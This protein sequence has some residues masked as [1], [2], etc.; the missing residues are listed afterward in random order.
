MAQ[1]CLGV[2]LAPILG[3]GSAVLGQQST[4]GKAKKA[5][6]L[7]MSGGMTHL[8]T[9]D[10]KPGTEVGGP[11]EAISTKASG[12]RISEHFPKLAQRLNKLTV[13]RGMTSNQGAHGPGRYLAH[14]SYAPRASIQHAGMGAW[15]ANV[16]G[17]LNKNIP[18]NIVINGGSDH[19]GAGY[20]DLKYAPLPIGSP[21]AGLKNSKL[22]G[23]VTEKDF[24]RRLNMVAKFGQQFLRRYPHKKVKGY[25]EMYAE[26]IRLMRSEDVKAF[27]V[28]EEDG[29]LRNEYGRDNFGQGCL[30]ARRLLERDVRFVEVQLGG[31][32][33]HNETFE[34]MPEKGRVVDNAVSALLD[35]LERT[36]LIKETVVILTSEFGRSPRINERAGRDHHPAAFSSL[37]AGAGIK[38]GYVHGASDERGHYVEDGE[39]PIES[40]NATIATAL[41][42]P[43]D[44]VEYSGSGRP[45]KVAN[46]GDAITEVFA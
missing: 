24:N 30:L 7:F 29:K 25:G 32:D 45:F 44:K 41:G 22:L 36:G 26:A 3:G 33:M 6:Y 46:D 31:W 27:D 43:L 18:A 19:P 39:A 37:I 11:T 8:D 1:A 28:N 34:A 15:V 13:I 40:L 12:V 23:G 21:T 10:P 4:T 2:G 5:I 35:D 38:G 42:I 14:T 17:Q 16:K 9:F 20:M